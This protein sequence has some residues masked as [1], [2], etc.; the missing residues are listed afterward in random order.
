MEPGDVVGGRFRL[1][2]EAA[3]GGMGVVWRARDR[4]D[5]LVA[6]K[7]MRRSETL[8]EAIATGRFA[9]EIE[10]L[11]SLDDPRIVRY[12]THGALDDG[13]P[14]LTVEWIDG[15]SLADR[16]DG[17]GLTAGESAT[18]VAEAAAGLAVAHAC[19]IV[20]R[21]VKPANLL[22]TAGDLAL[23][24]IIDFGVARRAGDEVHLTRTGTFV[25]TP[26]YIS[27]EQA[28]GSPELDPRSD[29][30][31][32]GCVLFECLTGRPAFAGRSLTAIRSK[33]LLY[34][35][36]A[37][38][39]MV[40][41]VPHELAELARQMM[42]KDPSLR[43]RDGREV[44]DALAEFTGIPGDVRQRGPHVAPATDVMP[45][46]LPPTRA[47][48]PVIATGE[49]RDGGVVA[50]VVIA[51]GGLGIDL[52]AVRLAVARHGGNL[53]IVAGGTILVTPPATLSPAEQVVRGTHAALA[54]RGLV[55]GP[56]VVVGPSSPTDLDTCLDE[57]VATLSDE[58]TRPP[59]DDRSVR[60][61]RAFAA[62]LRDHGFIIEQDESGAVLVL[63]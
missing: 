3:R 34:E 19:G 17:E 30:F 12:I 5:A 2:R 36:P 51:D 47:D 60:V 27:P 58:I 21:D 13:R 61:D 56:I 24:K 25:G 1:E 28:R 45:T 41:G 37:A 62:L 57:A 32:L 16:L 8:D 35:P 9:R 11:A 63:G 22:F 43:P 46:S 26:G 33:V 52:Q 49:T 23:L 59:R 55:D 18:V 20:H 50:C 40:A 14:Y 44:A 29:V 31:S 10:L 6:V 39:R 4:D 7:V 48:V 15:E 53:E 42:A 38:D 54:L